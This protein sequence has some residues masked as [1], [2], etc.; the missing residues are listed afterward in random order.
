[1]SG[2]HRAILCVLGSSALFTAS[3]A[4]VKALGG[5]VPLLQV[6]LFRNLVAMLVLTPLL[7]RAGGFTHLRT[8]RP[9]SHVLRAACGLVGMLGAYYSFVTLPLAAV[10]ALGFAMPLVLALVSVPLLG[11]R[12]GPARAAAMLAGF[13]G[14]LLIVRPWAGAAGLPLR[15]VLLTLGG[16][17]AWALAMVTI[18]RMGRVG[19]TSTTIVLW[20]SVTGTAVSALLALPGWTWPNAAQWAG[21]VAVGLLSG[22]AQILMTEGYRS[23]DATLVA[24]FEYGAILYTLVLGALIWSEWPGPWE[25]TGVAVLV[26]SGLLLWLGE[27][28]GGHTVPRGSLRS[29]AEETP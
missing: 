8:R 12:V 17:V 28:R 14:V 4:V 21:L 3:A 11:E 18:R 27:A 29:A 22:I 6:V 1:M 20:F 19:E 24:P 7:L 13:A 10:T 9:V 16:V 23:A 15:P 2:A 25:M 26:G 5:G